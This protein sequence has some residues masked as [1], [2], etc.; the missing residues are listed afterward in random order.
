MSEDKKKLFLTAIA[1]EKNM[2]PAEIL[3]ALISYDVIC[4]HVVDPLFMCSFFEKAL[5]APTTELR[6]PENCLF[7]ILSRGAWEGNQIMYRLLDIDTG[8]E[9][10]AQARFDE[11]ISLTI[12]DLF[13]FEHDLVDL[14]SQ[15]PALFTAKP[16]TPPKTEEPLSPKI[17][18]NLYA[19]IGVFLDMLVDKKGGNIIA[20][21]HEGYE[22]IFRIQEDLIHFIAN[23]KIYGLGKSS[24]HKIFRLANLALRNKPSD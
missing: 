1:K 24:L 8:N 16:T 20:K 4:A 6:I 10:S 15:I 5:R 12:E 3:E 2:E 23:E 9:H 7:V 21:P 11:N 19:L 18:E 22:Y 13:V 14:E 17:E